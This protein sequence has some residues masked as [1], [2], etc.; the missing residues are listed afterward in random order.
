MQMAPCSCQLGSMEFRHYTPH[1]E[2]ETEF[3]ER[4][5]DLVHTPEIRRLGVIRYHDTSTSYPIER[6]YDTTSIEL[7]PQVSQAL[8]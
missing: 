8:A 3:L 6:V 5:H 7:E 2:Y 1:E 4:R